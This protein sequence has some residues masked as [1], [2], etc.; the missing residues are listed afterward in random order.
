MATCHDHKLST[1]SDLIRAVGLDNF[2]DTTSKQDRISELSGTYTDATGNIDFE[3]FVLVRLFVPRFFQ[4]F[5]LKQGSQ[6]QMLY[7]KLAKSAKSTSFTITLEK[8]N[9]DVKMIRWM[10]TVQ[11]VH[12]GYL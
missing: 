5:F 2:G 8:A 7:K 6:F 12:A 1:F 3:E 10:S 9:N 4:D 11:Q